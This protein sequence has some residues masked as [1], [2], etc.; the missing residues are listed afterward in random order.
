M[1]KIEKW[2]KE[3]TFL[4]I[5]TDILQMKRVLEYNSDPMFH[6]AKKKKKKRERETE[7]KRMNIVTYR[8]IVF[9]IH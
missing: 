7:R 4:E 8:L 1:E 9:F 5:T 2:G 6:K 3:K